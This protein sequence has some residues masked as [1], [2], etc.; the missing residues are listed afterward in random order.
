MSRYFSDHNIDLEIYTPLNPEYP[1]YDESLLDDV[2]SNLKID[3]QPINE[4]YALYKKFTGKK[5]EEKI[6]SGFINDKKSFAQ[7]IAVWIRGNFFIPDARKF[8]IKPSIK[9][10]KKKLEG[11]TYDAIISTGPPHSMHLIALGI[12][13][14]Y[15]NLKWIADFRDPWTN[16]DFY[17]QLKL[18]KWADRKHRKME[19][20]VLQKADKVV[21]VGWTLAE[22][23]KNLSGISDV[24]V[25][26]NGYDHRDF[27][28]E[29]PLAQEFTIMHL[30]SMN[31]DRN[32]K[33]LWESLSILN[34][35]NIKPLVKIIGQTDISV[36]NS[37]QDYHLESQV[38]LEDFIPHDLAIQRM[39]SAH[40]LLLV[41]NNTPNAAGILTGK[42]FEYLGAKRPIIAI[43]PKE[44]DVKKML[45]EFHHA[46]YI[47]Y[48][49]VEDCNTILR[50]LY[51]KRSLY[52]AGDG[53]EK[54]SRKSLAGEYC[55]MIKNLCT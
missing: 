18:S 28:E 29:V 25:I 8:W 14:N 39:K 31:K 53:I 23:F 45:N 20:E 1:A 10:L 54:Y 9:Y 26:T 50:D 27:I 15:P 46:H 55:Q 35:E 40:V 5:K 51:Q 4:P 22:E 49:S 3:K 48:H 41:I 21:T 16:I 12:K 44:G 43:G 30:G 36:K 19:R 17:D 52:I 2:D 7:S 38:M 13:K 32:P 34:K 47:D 37:I 42:L 11:E 6:Y 33:V 24:A